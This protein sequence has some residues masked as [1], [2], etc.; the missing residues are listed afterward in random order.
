MD[1]MASRSYKKKENKRR[2]LSILKVTFIKK[3]K[4]KKK[5][6][7]YTSDISFE[8]M[9]MMCSLLF[10]LRITIKAYSKEYIH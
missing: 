5:K 7:N 3:K 2:N 6:K 1:G 4:R 10:D 8:Y 9:F